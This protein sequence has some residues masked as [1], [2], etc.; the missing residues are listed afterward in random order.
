MPAKRELEHAQSAEPIEYT[1]GGSD[2]DQYGHGNHS[3][4]PR[5]MNAAARTLGLPQ[6]AVI[7][8]TTQFRGELEAGKTIITTAHSDPTQRTRIFEQEMSNPGKPG[9]KQ[10]LHTQVLPEGVTLAE[11]PRV[12]TPPK[13]ESIVFDDRKVFIKKKDGDLTSD[14][15]IPVLENERFEILKSRGIDLIKLIDQNIYVVVIVVQYEPRANIPANTS[16]TISNEVFFD[17]PKSTVFKQVITADGI[18]GEITQL[19]RAV[20]MRRDENGRPRF[21]RFP[22][23]LIRGIKSANAQES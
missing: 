1:L 2:I 4:G 7:G 22:E 5:E 12:I 15:V 18:P 21:S 6:A 23:D 20:C 11:L 16:V 8:F 14:E 9:V 17:T 19:T 13:S 10:M 3:V